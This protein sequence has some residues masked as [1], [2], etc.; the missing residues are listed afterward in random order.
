M[1]ASFV[2][3]SLQPGGDAVSAASIA[4]VMAQMGSDKERDMLAQAL[5][6]QGVDPGLVAQGRERFKEER[7]ITRVKRIGGVWAVL[8]TASMALSAYHG[9]KR[10][11]SIGWALVWGFLGAIAPVI[12]P[13][14]AV[15]Q[16]FGKRSK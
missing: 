9:Y 6:T 11:D 8:G 2:N 15:A 14:I 12:T 7:A 13:T 16:G 4:D 5:I 3:L 1:A 10:N